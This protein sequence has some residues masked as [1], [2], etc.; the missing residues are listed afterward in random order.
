MKKITNRALLVLAAMLI[1][2]SASAFEFDDIQFWV[3]SGPNQAALVI[4]WNDG[5]SPQSLAWGLRWG[6]TATGADMLSAIDAAD[7][8]LAV[9]GSV[10]Q[11]GLF[12]NGMSYYLGAGSTHDQ[13]TPAD[14]SQS[15]SYWVG[16]SATSPNWTSSQVGASSRLLADNCWDGWSF[17]SWDASY[18]PITLPGDPVAA[19]VPEPSSLLPLASGLMSLGGLV[20]RRRIS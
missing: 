11:Y 18:N 17:T 10:G 15:W 8:R 20:L 9:D 4:D 16:D 3:G 6:G 5:I 12:V 19:P 7:S 2:S 14:W 13:T 1:A